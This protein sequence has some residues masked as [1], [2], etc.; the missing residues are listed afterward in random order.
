MAKVFVFQTCDKSGDHRL[1]DRLVTN[2]ADGYKWVKEVYPWYK[3]YFK[4][5]TGSE[6][7]EPSQEM[8][9]YYHILWM[10]GKD[11]KDRDAHHI[12]IEHRNLY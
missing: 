3:W 7:E 5:T 9:E 12:L 1:V 11:Q 8:A 10:I 6:I 2:V 4:D